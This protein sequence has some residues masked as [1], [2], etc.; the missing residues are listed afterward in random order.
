[1]EYRTNFIMSLLIGIIPVFIQYYLWTAIFDNSTSSTIHGYSYSQIISYTI[2][3][4]VVSKIIAT[5]FENE[6]AHDIKSGGLSTFLVKP[7]SYINL[8][9]FTFLGGK[10]VQLIIMAF[11]IVVILFLMNTYFGIDN[12]PQTIITFVISIILA[13]ILNFFLFFCI[14]TLAFWMTDTW[15]VFS[16][17]QIVVS[18]VSGGILPL[19][20]FGK[21]MLTFFSYTPFKYTVYFPV[22]ILSGKLDISEVVWGIIIQAIWVVVLLLIS[23]VL[24]NIGSKK[25]TA[26]GG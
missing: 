3:S 17:A 6:I 25:Y 11:F 13:I 26:T 10:S 21:N 2:M 24:W 9:V 15:G 19:D 8:K 16:L 5:G 7:V 20:M 12:G 22:N 23:Q 1:M 14:S 18:I 4:G